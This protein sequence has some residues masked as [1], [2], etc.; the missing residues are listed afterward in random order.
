[1]EEIIH[2]AQI[3]KILEYAAVALLG[4]APLCTAKVDPSGRFTT[5]NR[6]VTVGG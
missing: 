3:A 6:P 4:T 2:W 1:M 5:E